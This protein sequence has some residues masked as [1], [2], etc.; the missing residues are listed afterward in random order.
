MA[1]LQKDENGLWEWKDASPELRDWAQVFFELRRE[2][3]DPA[4]E[5]DKAEAAA[6]LAAA[7]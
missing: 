4:D 3:G 2:D 6:K 1:D 5:A 7:G